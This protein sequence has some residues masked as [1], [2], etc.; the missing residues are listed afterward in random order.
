VGL[1][2]SPLNFTASAVKKSAGQLVSQ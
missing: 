1:S 2:G